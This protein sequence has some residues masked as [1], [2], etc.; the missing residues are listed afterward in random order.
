MGGGG[1]ENMLPIIGPIIRGG[2]CL[3]FCVGEVCFCFLFL[4]VFG[5]H[6]AKQTTNCLRGSQGPVGSLLVGA[7]HRPATPGLDLVLLNNLAFLVGAPGAGPLLSD[8]QSSP[9][10]GR[11]S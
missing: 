4:C 9:R 5:N 2:G 10:L 6:S 7:S 1:G 8:V 3:C 11:Q